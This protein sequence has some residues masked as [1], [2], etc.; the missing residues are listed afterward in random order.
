VLPPIGRSVAPVIRTILLP[1]R[2]QRTGRPPKF[3]FAIQQKQSLGRGTDLD[4]LF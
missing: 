4:A 3:L 1:H 2:A